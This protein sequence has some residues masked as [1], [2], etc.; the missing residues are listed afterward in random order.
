MQVL[1]YCSSVSYWTQNVCFQLQDLP[2][3]SNP[4]VGLPP[5]GESSMLSAGLQRPEAWHVNQMYTFHRTGKSQTL[6][7]CNEASC[8]KPY[9]DQRDMVDHIYVA[10]LGVSLRHSCPH[11]SRTFSWRKGLAQHKKLCARMQAVPQ[12][13]S[14]QLCWFIVRIV[15]KGAAICLLV[16]KC[17]HLLLLC[18]SRF[19]FELWTVDWNC[20]LLKVLAL[21][22][23][24][25]IWNLALALDANILMFHDAVQWNCKQLVPGEKV[26]T[27]CLCC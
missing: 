1:N 25:D 6:Y 16:V 22:H 10:H 13:N 9:R 3:L 5:A 7:V 23:W 26:Y 2:F 24:H 20:V 17:E 21:Q 11:C 4:G 8:R 15:S 14:A 18:W 27:S 19:L 12:N